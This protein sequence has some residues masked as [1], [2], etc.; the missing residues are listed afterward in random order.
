MLDGKYK[1]ENESKIQEYWKEKKIFEFKENKDKEIYSVDT[2]PPTVSGKLHVGHIFSYTQA[3]IIVRYKRIMG[4]NVYYPFGFDDNGLPTERLVEKET[5]KKAK[6]YPRSE[7]AKICSETANKYVLEFIDMWSSLGFSVDWGLTYETNNPLSQ[8]IS[9]YSF[10]ELAQKGKAYQKEKPVLWCINCQT[11]IAQAEL[12]SKEGETNFNY[13]PFYI[14]DELVEVAT[15]RPEFLAGCKALLINPLDKRAKKYEGKFAKVPL[16]NFLVPVILDEDVQLEKG[17]GVVMCCTYGDNVDV[18]WCQKYS[19][20]YTRV[21]G[22]NGVIDEKID[23]IG[24]LYVTKARATIIEILKEKGLLL[25]QEIIT[26]SVSTHERCGTDVEILPSNQWYIDVLTDKEKYIKAA[27]ELNW[28][29]TF[30]KNRYLTWVENLKWDWCISRQRYYGVPFPVWYCQK[31]GKA[32]FAKLEDLPVNPLETK[33]EGICS[34]G[35]NEFTPDK[36]VMDTWATSS[37]SPLIN[38]KWKQP[39][40]KD[41]LIPMSMRTQAHE[42]IRTWAFYT[43]VKS[44]Y[45]TGQLPWK[46]LM[47]T[48]FVLANRGEKIS[49]SKNNA[50]LSPSALIE[51]YGADAV[52]YWTASNKLGTDTSFSEDD[53]KS[54][55]RF[56]TKFWNASKFILMQI[57]D[58]DMSIPEKLKDVDQ[59]LLSRFYQMQDKYC[60][61]MD[62]YEVG[63]ARKEIDTFFWDDLCD[64]YLEIAKERLYQPQKHGIEN[65]LSG[66]YTLY[67]VLLGLLSL[68]SVFVPHECEEIYLHYFLEKEKTLSVSQIEINKQTYD[69]DLI[70]KGEKLIEL[71]SQ[72]RKYKTDRNLSMKAPIAKLILE[73]EQKDLLFFEDSKNDLIACL[74]IENF[75]IIKKDKLKIVIEGETK[76]A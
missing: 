74:G 73:I 28:H 9:Q 68:Y 42:I 46:D 65:T 45:H 33:Y 67:K 5:S 54:S 41:Y 19:L 2:P 39:D 31:C 4:F 32:H 27:D 36:D 40:Q 57:K 23:F 25:K 17:S 71:V 61:A 52:R 15:T 48:G 58:Y 66:Q 21:I 30:M 60:N 75:V 10:I 34:C 1:I 59:W 18:E 26:H 8:K 35:H 22:E 63:I 76:N 29:P 12:D 38:A 53:I 50:T 64:N 47:I 6:D 11:S 62:Q 69:K 43:I 7:F 16:Y 20:D 37:V 24:G 3:E 49:K 44:L 55:N 72:A 56:L 51:R 70:I 14:D 13:I